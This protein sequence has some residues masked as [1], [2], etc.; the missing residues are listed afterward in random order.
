LHIAAHSPKFAKAAGIAQSVAQDFHAADK[1][2]SKRVQAKARAALDKRKPK[3]RT[4]REDAQDAMEAHHN[5]ME[6]AK[7]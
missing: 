5:A 2:K 6:E 4:V 1:A 7:G 3:S